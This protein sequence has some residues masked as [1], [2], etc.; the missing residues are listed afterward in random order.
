M[1]EQQPKTKPEMEQTS[2]EQTP[3]QKIQ[4]LTELLQRTQA[5]FENYRKQTEKRVEELQQIAGKNVLFQL[6]PLVDNLELAFKNIH[7]PETSSEF[8]DGIKLIYGQ[9][10]TILENNGVQV[11]VTEQK[12]YDPHRHEALMKVESE[13][14][15]GTILEEFQKGFTL[16]GQVL[17]HAKVKIS[18]GK[19]EQKTAKNEQTQ[20]KQTK[21]D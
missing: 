3:E 6:L 10:M 9:L 20:E 18:A 17:R 7:E 4:E 19:T 13:L 11:I 12:Q 5:N 1:T 14:P 21:H 15:T 2:T 16:R 8:L